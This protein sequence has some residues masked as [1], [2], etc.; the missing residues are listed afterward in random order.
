M[1]TDKNITCPLLLFDLEENAFHVM[2]RININGLPTLALIDSGASKTV[3]TE[4]FAQ[5]LN[6]SMREADA[7]SASESFK[8]KEA[9]V[10][11]ML[12][13]N[14]KVSNLVI[15]VMNFDHIQAFYESRGLE[16]FDLV[17][18]ADILLDFN[19][20]LDFEEQTLVFSYVKE[21]EL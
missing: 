14:I 13:E 3:Y 4:V 19:A 15:G 7:V 8:S 9:T 2:T 1:Q 5:K 18:G 11:I 10:D 16:M 20:T 12:S 21:T 6:L 17:I